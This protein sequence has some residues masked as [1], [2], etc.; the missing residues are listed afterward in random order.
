M[1]IGEFGRTPDMPAEVARFYGM[2]LQSVNTQKK[3]GL[4]RLKKV[5]LASVLGPPANWD[6]LHPKPRKK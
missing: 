6:K 2:S 3:R 5:Y 1:P 4:A